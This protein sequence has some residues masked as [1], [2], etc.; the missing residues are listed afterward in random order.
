MTHVAFPIPFLA[1]RVR[2][3]AP[4]TQPPNASDPGC[5]AWW[6]QAVQRLIY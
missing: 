1:Q 6:G 2:S 4:E 5:V 3:E